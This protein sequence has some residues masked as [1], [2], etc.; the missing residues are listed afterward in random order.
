MS[1]QD[2]FLYL[3]VTRH[4]LTVHR[5]DTNPKEEG[6]CPLYWFLQPAR[7]PSTFFNTAVRPMYWM[8]LGLNYISCIVQTVSQIF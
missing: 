7:P 4:K 3:I 6:P 1:V 5:L 8:M 2:G